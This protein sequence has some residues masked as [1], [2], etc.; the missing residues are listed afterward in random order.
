MTVSP[1]TRL[2]AY[3]IRAKLGEGGRG[4]VYRGREPRPGHADPGECA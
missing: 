3:E 1:G 4:G 2:G